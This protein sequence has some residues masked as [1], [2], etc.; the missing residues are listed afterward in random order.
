MTPN[1]IALR[2]EVVDL[3]KKGH[4]QDLLLDK[5]KNTLSQCDARHD[6]QPA[7]PTLERIVNV[8]TSA[9]KVSGI[10]YSTA[11]QHARTTV[12]PKTNL[13]PTPPSGASNLLLFFIDN[14]DSTLI[15][16]YHDGLVITLLIANC[17]IKRIIIDNSSSTNV[18]FLN[19][20]REMNTDKSYIYRR[21]TVLVSFSGE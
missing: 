2:F 20:L 7:K 6:D 1:C 16:P 12:N 10:T 5:G 14:E 21:S 15:N 3:L 11:R 9:S 18:I 13:S 4:L 17:K 8:I 19:A